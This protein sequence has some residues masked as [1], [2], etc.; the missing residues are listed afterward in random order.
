MSSLT[1]VVQVLS[2]SDIGTTLC[3]DTIIYDYRDYYNRIK[4]QITF[5]FSEN[6]L[7]YTR[8]YEQF[9]EERAMRTPEQVNEIVSR[10]EDEYPLAE[11]T[12]DF[13]KD[14]ELLFSV[15]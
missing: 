9:Q 8:F 14:Y 5:I 6:M 11:C 4:R 15:R 12:L 1:M 7:E 2:V 13:R 3:Q 10:L